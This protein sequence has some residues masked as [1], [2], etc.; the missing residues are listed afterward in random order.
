M[1]RRC[2]CRQREERFFAGRFPTYW[3]VVRRA[4]RRRKVDDLVE[5]AQLPPPVQSPRRLHSGQVLVCALQATVRE[6]QTM[7]DSQKDHKPGTAAAGAKVE[8]VVP[9][10]AVQEVPA[11]PIHDA[12]H[13]LTPEEEAIMWMAL[14]EYE[15]SQAL[16]QSGEK[17]N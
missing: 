1:T 7:S 14:E 9:E 5:C 17:K 13:G 3:C 2:C 8:P 11:T 6:R 16:V 4:W 10:K 12:D 15:R